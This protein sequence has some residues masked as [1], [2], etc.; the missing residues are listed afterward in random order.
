MKSGSSARRRAAI[1]SSSWG[2][3]FSVRPFCAVVQRDISGQVRQR[4]PKTALLADV[5]ATV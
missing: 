1:I 4:V 2:W 3:R 5:M